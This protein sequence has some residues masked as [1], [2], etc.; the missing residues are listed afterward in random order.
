MLNTKVLPF[1][2]AYLLIPHFMR[3]VFLATIFILDPCM[4]SAGYIWQISY[5]MLLTWPILCRAERPG[6]LCRC[7]A[8]QNKRSVYDYI[9]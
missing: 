8:N 4:T 5:S 2:C 6:L 9:S 1:L 7:V 3:A